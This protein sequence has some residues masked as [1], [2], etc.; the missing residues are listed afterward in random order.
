MTTY[1]TQFDIEEIKEMHGYESDQI[2][3]S[4]DELRDFF[5]SQMQQ[6]E[7][8]EQMTLFPDDIDGLSWRDF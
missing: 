3:L 6:E 4:D 8:E 2:D 1:W 5:E 7:E